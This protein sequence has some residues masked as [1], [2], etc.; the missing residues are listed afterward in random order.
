MKKSFRPKVSNKRSASSSP[1]AKKSPQFKSTLGKSPQAQ[2]PIPKNC[3]AVVGTHAIAEAIHVRPRDIKEAWL[4]QGFESS[5]DLRELEQKL[6]KA[7]V[8]VDLKPSS[9]LDRIFPNNQGA[10]IFVSSSPELDWERLKHSSYSAVLA[11][12]GIEDPHNLGA[13]LRTAWLMEVDGVFLPQD[14]SVGMTATVHKVACGGVEHVAVEKVVNFSNP[15]E[16]LKKNG[17]WVFGLSHKA[18]HSLFDIKLPEKV[19]WCIGSED[20]G[21]RT[22]T[23]RLCD[24]LV[25][26]PQVSAAA[27]Y[28]ASVATAI[29]LSETY[30]QRIIAQKTSSSLK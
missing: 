27:S 25:S 4:Q 1:M 16:E 28:N 2:I 29:A 21:M 8:I 11:L 15:I 5:Q 17:F 22:T 26:I 18:K 19:V 6:K 13:I 3:R 12:D 9:V 24:E 7:G 10:A 23:E 20:K 14:R 30:R